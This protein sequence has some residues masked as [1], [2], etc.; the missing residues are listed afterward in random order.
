MGMMCALF[1]MMREIGS[2]VAASLL[3]LTLNRGMELGGVWSGLPFMFATAAVSG[4]ACLIGCG[5]RVPAER[6]TADRLGDAEKRRIR[7]V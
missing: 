1:I 5:V 6:D 3:S 2:V 7:K 4:A